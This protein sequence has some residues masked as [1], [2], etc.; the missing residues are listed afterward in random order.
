MPAYEYIC[1]NCETREFRIGGLDDHTVI[2]D[3]C[4]QV[5]VRKVDPDTLLAS[6]KQSQADGSAH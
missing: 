5:M 2:C 3:S 1:S 4:G 6:Y